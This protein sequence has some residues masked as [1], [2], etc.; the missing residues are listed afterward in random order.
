M[1]NLQINELKFILLNQEIYWGEKTAILSNLQLIV[2][3]V[4]YKKLDH[5]VKFS[6]NPMP[7]FLNQC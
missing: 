4:N 3:D 7:L 1:Y 5:L 6:V 2:L